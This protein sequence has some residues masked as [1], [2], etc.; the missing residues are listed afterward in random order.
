MVVLKEG[1]KRGSVVESNP[2]M[3]IRNKYLHLMNIVEEDK[4]QASISVLANRSKNR[5]KG[6]MMQPENIMKLNYS[7]PR[8]MKMKMKILLV[9]VMF[10]LTRETTSMLTLF[11]FRFCMILLLMLILKPIRLFFSI[12]L[13][14]L[15]S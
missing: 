1:Y 10:V 11:D 2:L 12:D 13:L 7:T 9:V 3:N 8:M 4:Q 14:L 15:I 5:K 6:Q